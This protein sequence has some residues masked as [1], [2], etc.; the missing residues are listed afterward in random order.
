[1]STSP[2][3]PTVQPAPSKWKGFVC[4][5]VALLMAGS[6]MVYQRLTGPTHPMRGS[7]TIGDQSYDYKLL[8]SHETTAEAPIQIP[9]PGENVDAI[10]SWRRYSSNPQ[11]NNE[12][13]TNFAMKGKSDPEIFSKE[14]IKEN[15][16]IGLL[17]RQPAAG[18]VEYYLTLEEGDTSQ[19][20][21]SN[22]NETVVLRYKDP[23]PNTVLI[24]HIVCMILTIICGMRAALA[25]LFTPWCMRLYSWLALGFMTIGGMI[26]GPIVQK[27]AFGEYWTGFPFGGD[28]TDNKTLVMWLAWL[29]A[30]TVI[31]FSA[32]KKEG[33]GR[34][35]VVLA[36]LVMTAVYIIPHSMGG[37][38]ADYELI[39][40][41][42]DPKEAIKTGKQ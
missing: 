6:A 41:G 8:R 31:G 12:E 28:W 14:E 39:D 25:A 33:P 29:V 13:Y 18:K 2:V 37:S 21:P 3:E 16:V 7:F 36:A 15:S 23:V 30:C 10:L 1:M 4:W 27:Y 32:R 35:V 17:P 22:Q 19:R 20:I 24:P 5:I 9:S 38:E 26:L 40:Q 11:K 42:V 34:G